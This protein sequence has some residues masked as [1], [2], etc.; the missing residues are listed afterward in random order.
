[1]A[2]IDYY[3]VLGVDS[4]ASQSD[5]RKAYRKMAKKYHPD[6][7]KDNPEAE[8]HFQ[9]INE[10]NEVLSDPEKR[11]KYDEYGEH[12]KHADEYEA[13]R[14]E[15]GQRRGYENFGGFGDFTNSGNSSGFSDF[16]EELF[17]N[18]AG[19]RN[20]RRA[21]TQGEDLQAELFLTL[22]EAAETHKRI[23][24]INGETIRL[25][26]PAGIADG[27][28]I[29]VKGHGASTYKGGI[30]GDLYITFRIEP[31][32]TFTREGDNLYTTT[33]IDIYTLLLGGELI[34][35]TLNGNVKI[36]IQKNTP[37]K[38][39]LRL[40]GKGFPL[41]KKKGENGDL[42]VSLELI[43]PTLNAKQEELLREMKKAED[44]RQKY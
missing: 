36:K 31:D 17:G 1:M 7:N 6:I 10:A 11:K 3:K 41:Y 15:Y 12:W 40:R 9:A 14:K 42:Y 38:N 2:F 23:L 16:F 26:V 13:Q 29:R 4:K 34:V 25:T 37:L 43:Q 5:I 27:Q 28:K 32:R 24:D 19:R 33:Q 35:P 39:R 22:R 30:R 8:K 44:T 20:N 21:T 18:F